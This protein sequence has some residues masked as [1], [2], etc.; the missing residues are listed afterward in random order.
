MKLFGREIK[1]RFMSQDD[2][3]IDE[4]KFLVD[5]DPK[6]GWPPRKEV[7][8]YRRRPNQLHP[9]NQHSREHALETEYL[10]KYWRSGTYEST[11]EQWNAIEAFC[12]WRNKELVFRWTKTD[13]HGKRHL[14]LYD[15]DKTAY[16]SES[17]IRLVAGFRQ[18]WDTLPEIPE[19][20]QP[21]Q[22]RI[23]QYLSDRRTIQRAAVLTVMLWRGIPYWKAAMGGLTP[24]SRS[25]QGKG[26][27]FVQG[28]NWT[29]N[30]AITTFVNQAVTAATFTMT[31]GGTTAT[32]NQWPLTASVASTTGIQSSPNVVG[33]LMSP[34]QVAQVQQQQ[35]ALQLMAA[36]AKADI[37]AKKQA[38]PPSTPLD[39]ATMQPMQPIKPQPIIMINAPT[40][41]S[42]ATAAQ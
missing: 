35:M 27:V 13:K 38:L 33:T 6:E 15:G 1:F 32:L 24:K 39:P 37:Y 26:G 11:I 12:T 23:V 10:A 18:W 41:S 25:Q 36:Q 22:E 7:L 30:N 28:G 5:R 31:T 3:R 9:N 16:V 2:Q 42:I 40:D 19:P 14:A 17:D 34:Q 20:E 21:V 8:R 29:Q 4:K